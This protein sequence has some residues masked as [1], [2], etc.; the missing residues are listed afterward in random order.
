MIDLIGR[1]SGTTE[2]RSGRALDKFERALGIDVI[3][4]F[5]RLPLGIP[6]KRTSEISG[7]DPSPVEH[8]QQP[9]D[10]PLSAAHRAERIADLVLGKPMRWQRSGERE[11]MRHGRVPSRRAR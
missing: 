2:A 9:L 1:N 7:F 6:L 10:A 3:P 8:R 11:D 5:E 4:S